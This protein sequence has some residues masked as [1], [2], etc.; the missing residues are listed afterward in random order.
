MWV[1][2]GFKGRLNFVAF[3]SA[4]NRAAPQ[5][6][7]R[8]HASGGALWFYAG[9]FG[10]TKQMA[11]HRAWGGGEIVPRILP[12]LHPPP[13]FQGRRKFCAWDGMGRNTLKESNHGHCF[14]LLRQS[15]N[16]AW[17]FWLF[18]IFEALKGVPKQAAGRCLTPR[19]EGNIGGNFFLTYFAASWHP[20][21][22]AH[23]RGAE[24]MQRAARIRTALSC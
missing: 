17:T 12:V 7:R 6:S 23:G 18:N 9:G 14:L 11:A 24:D 21:C 15:F 20:P 2:E 13:K 3:P 10:F 1:F 8:L 16:S 19:F 4:R 22:S 5:E